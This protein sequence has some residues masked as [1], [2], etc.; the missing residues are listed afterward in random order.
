MTAT[1]EP[2]SNYEN[3]SVNGHALC[4]PKLWEAHKAEVERMRRRQT[5]YIASLPSYAPDAIRSAL[6]VLAPDAEEMPPCL[7]RAGHLSALLEVALR[8]GTEENLWQARESLAWAA[9]RLATDLSDMQRLL[10]T[11]LDHLRAP[12]GALCPEHA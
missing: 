4:N 6:K 2:V 3:E 8:N 10:A 5:D 12:I 1:P 11:A 9:E 7:E